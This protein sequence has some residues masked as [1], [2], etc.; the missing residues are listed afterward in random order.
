M[1]QPSAPARV[2][3]LHKSAFWIY[4]VTAM[5][6]REPLGIVLRHASAAG[7]RDP[8]VLGEILR[9]ALVLA[10]MSRLFLSSGLYFDRVY[11]RPDSGVRFP[12][13]SYPVDFLA[14]LLQFLLAVGAST[15]IAGPVPTFALTVAGFLLFDLAWLALSGLLGYAT[16]GLIGRP[17]W[18]AAAGCAT[19]TAM[20]WLVSPNAAVALLLGLTGWETAR[21]VR[22]YNEAAPSAAT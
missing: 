5:V 9:T 19:G 10:L 18:T 2:S 13:R 6:M 8:A 12:R 14:G 22:A 7:V 3:D 20:Y 15:V 17:A 1:S 4:G 21:L 16:T 11:L